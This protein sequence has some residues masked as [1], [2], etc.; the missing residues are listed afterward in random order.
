M[1]SSA[2]VRATAAIVIDAVRR[3]GRSLDVALDKG[4]LELDVKDQALLAELSYGT[5]RHYRSLEWLLGRLLSKPMPKKES[6]AEALLLLA[7][8]EQWQMRTPSHAAVSEAVNAMRMLKRPALAR[9]ANA[10]LRRFGREKMALL[11]ALSDQ[12][13]AVTTSHPDWLVSRIQNDWP[14]Y[15]QHI[16]EANNE[17]APM[18]LRVN[19]HRGA[20]DAYQQRLAAAGIQATPHDAAP[21]ALMLD[22]PVGVDA[23]PGFSSGDVSVQD[24]SPQRVVALCQVRSGMR[25]L[26][27]CCAPGGKT[28]HL[29]ESVGGEAD[30][31]AVELDENRMVRVAETLARLNLPAKLVVG[32]AAKP[33]DWWDGELFDVVLVDAP[34]TATGVIRRHPDIKSLRRAKD[35]PN[36]ASRQLEMLNELAAL[37]RPGGCLVY[38]TC[39]VLKAENHEVVAEF[40]RQNEVFSPA[41]ELRID[42]NNGLMAVDS[43]GYQCFP[44]NDGGDGFFLS[45]LEK[46]SAG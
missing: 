20:K 44:A 24:L 43:L 30:L 14:E 1:S 10:I 35:V 6:R 46:D 7:L 34:C 27:A 3:H 36:L 39:S 8:Y 5:L 29:L 45:R 19:Q 13:V 16:L 32:N 26:D 4:R 42:N 25:V 11:A 31:V 2:A 33:A 22:K 38:A 21:D 17:R 15:A 9:L 37:V 23:L 28:A 40:I 12:S 18:W 41:N